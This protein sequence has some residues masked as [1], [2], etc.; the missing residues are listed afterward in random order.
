MSHPDFTHHF[1]LYTDASQVA[2]GAVLAQD[3]DR[4]EK[5]V[6]YAGQSLTASECRWSIH[7]R[8]LWAIVWTVCH[9]RHYLGLCPFSIVT[10][11]SHY[12]G[13]GGFTSIMT[14]QVCAA[15]GPWNWTLMTG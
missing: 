10:I 12:L 8:E 4:L 13:F 1:I 9:S 14:E 15:A 5:V 2:E 6:A 3:T 7:D 11:T